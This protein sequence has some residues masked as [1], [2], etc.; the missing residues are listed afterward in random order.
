M[1]RTASTTRTICSSSR[2]RC[3][4]AISAADRVSALAVGDPRPRPAPRPITFAAISR[5][6]ASRWLAARHRRRPRGA[7]QLS[8]RRRVRIPAGAVSHEPRCHPRPRAR[9]RA[10]DRRRR[11]RV[12]LA[13]SAAS[14]SRVPAETIITDRAD[15][16]DARLRVRVPVRAGPRTGRRRHSSAR[17][18]AGTNR[19]RPFVRSN[20]G[21]YDSTGRPHVETLTVTGPFKPT[22]AGRHAEPPSASSS[23]APASAAEQDE[24]CAR[25]ILIDARAA[26]VPAPR[27]DA[28]PRAAAAVLPRRP[29]RRRLRGRHPARA[30][31]AAGEPDLRVPHRARSRRRRARRGVSRSATSSSPRGCRSSSGAACPT[32]SCSTLAARGRLRDPPCS[33]R[34][35]GACWPTREPRR[36]S[37]TSPVSG[38]TCATSTRRAEHRRLP[39]LRRRPAH[40]LPPRDRALLREHRDEDRSVL[41]LLTADYT[42]VN[43]RLARHYGIP[44]VYGSRFRRVTLGRRGAP[45]AARQGQHPDGH[46]ARRSHRAV[47]CA[48]NGF[49]RIC[50]ARRRR[51]RPPT[52][53]RWSRRPARRRRR[54]ASG[55]K[56]IAR[57]RRAPAATALIDPLGFALENLRRR[58]GVAYARRR[59]R[60]RR[61]R[62]AAG[63][64]AVA[65]SAS[66]ARRCCG[67]R[68]YSWVRL[69]KS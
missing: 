13:P 12:L 39:R 38:C 67:A 49:S 50:S 64:H 32:T 21:T 26:R 3:S 34:R 28:R 4:S 37:R 43:E 60:R 62:P 57:T 1:P 61:E 58:G 23:A 51:R 66:C 9:A 47:A 45:R 19:L 63:R 11:R 65:A 68:E 31:P 7:A 69:P 55:W 5:K 17:S 36:S 48:A 33:R 41:D 14:M 44:N 27:G 25:E 10:R 29:R 59:R 6:P 53:R 15:A 40:G 54:C 8:A 22:G 46:V 24:P 16:T 2:R 20:A 56:C 42:F 35:C 18:G 30:A 52:C